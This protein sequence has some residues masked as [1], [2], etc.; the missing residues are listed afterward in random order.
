MTTQLIVLLYSVGKGYRCMDWIG[1]SLLA[2]FKTKLTKIKT[3]YALM[4]TKSIV[5]FKL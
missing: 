2:Q 1:F 5:L 4:K 3:V